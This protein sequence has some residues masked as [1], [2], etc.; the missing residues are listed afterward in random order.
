VGVAAVQTGRRYVGFDI[1]E[2]YVNLARRRIEKAV[3]P[4][5][6]GAG[7][8]FLAGM[9]ILAIAG[10]VYIIKHPLIP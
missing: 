8:G 2:E 4:A 5:A 6:A 9:G 10:I 7:I 3:P 1:S